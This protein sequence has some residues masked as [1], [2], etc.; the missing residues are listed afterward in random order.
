MAGLNVAFLEQTSNSSDVEFD[1]LSG[2]SFPEG[3]G[4]REK[5]SGLLKSVHIF[6]QNSK[7]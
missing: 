1:E 6:K 5:S 4:A 7:L 3:I 2:R